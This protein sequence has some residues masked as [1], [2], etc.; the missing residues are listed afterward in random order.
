MSAV[1][2]HDSERLLKGIGTFSGPPSSAHFFKIIETIRTALPHFASSVLNEGIEDEKG[3]NGRLARFINNIADHQN[4]PYSAQIES[5]EDETRGDSPAAD[6]GIHLKV[7]DISTDPP[8][9]T[10]FEGKRLSANLDSRRRREYVIG[11]EKNGKHIPCGGIERFKLS[12]HGGKF[13]RAGMIGYM[14]DGSP[15]Q[16]LEKINGW[17]SEL[18]LQ[19]HSPNWSEE[20]LLVPAVTS[21]QVS[22]SESI[23]LRK[24]D[25]IQLVHLWIN[26]IDKPDV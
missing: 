10:V 25:K 20:E 6:I 4:M 15:S 13:S 5:M 3:L 9:I 24:N 26:L 2:S 18:S 22:K 11:H 23:V 14:Q 8:K 7:D 19:H 16:W 21:G 17:V 1:V 12:V